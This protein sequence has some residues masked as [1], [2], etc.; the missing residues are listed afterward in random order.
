MRMPLYHIINLIKEKFL[1]SSTSSDPIIE[2]RCNDFYLM[3]SQFEQ[4]GPFPRPR[5][6]HGTILKNHNPWIKNSCMYRK[7]NF[8]ETLKKKIEKQMFDK[9]LCDIG[10]RSPSHSRLLFVKKFYSQN[11]FFWLGWIPWENP[12]YGLTLSEIPNLLFFLFHT[13][14]TV[15]YKLFSLHLNS[16]LWFLEYV[17][18]RGHSVQTIRSC[19][20]K[21]HV[22]TIGCTVSKKN[23]ND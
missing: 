8:V 3:N 11:F 5:E 20:F 18:V 16:F 22:R 15:T 6:P 1:K 21:G 23:H 19:P 13:L 4:L 2:L 9:F 7:I 12:N 10:I 17:N 14:L